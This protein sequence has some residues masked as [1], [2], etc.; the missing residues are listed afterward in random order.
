MGLTI[1][2][3]FQARWTL[4][5]ESVHRLVQ[6]TARLA[7]EIGCA[8]VGQVLRS[9][10]GD[11][12]APE[13]FQTRWGVHRRGVGGSG[14]TGWLVE[15]WPGEGCATAVFGL[16]RHR[17][18]NPGAWPRISRP[19]RN[20]RWEL[21]D[22]CKTMYAAE[23]GL[24]HFVRCHERIILLLDLWRRSSVQVRV[25]DEGGFWKTRSR[26]ALAAQIGDLELFRKVAA[27]YICS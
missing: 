3:S 2:Y 15:V 13:F 18:R 27:C 24:D 22:F 9:C 14:T 11:R 17:P 4:R 21:H 12:D 5:D 16:M 23:H 25:H 10:D 6:R 8:H 1:K 26:E 7:Q 19:R 20:S